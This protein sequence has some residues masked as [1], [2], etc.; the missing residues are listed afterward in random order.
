MGATNQGTAELVPT[1]N[2]LSA[3]ANKT[4]I[5]APTTA[6]RRSCALTATGA[7]QKAANQLESL[8]ARVIGAWAIGVV[9]DQGA[10]AS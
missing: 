1:I 2:R 6:R 8:A 7:G 10:D 9:M 3:A 4:P 5:T